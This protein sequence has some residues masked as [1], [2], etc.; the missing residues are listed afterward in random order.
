MEKHEELNFKKEKQV[1]NFFTLCSL[2]TFF[3]IILF[4]H[5]RK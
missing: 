3:K 5:K 2:V 4:G 1:K